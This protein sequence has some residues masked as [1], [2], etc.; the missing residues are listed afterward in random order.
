MEFLWVLDSR[1]RGANSNFSHRKNNSFWDPSFGDLFVNCLTEVLE[2]SES[3]LMNFYKF[4]DKV[5]MSK[6]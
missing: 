6:Q 1:I 2:Q 4:N 3:W 5:C